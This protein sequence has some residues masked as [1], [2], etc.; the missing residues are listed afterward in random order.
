MKQVLEVLETVSDLQALRAATSQDQLTSTSRDMQGGTIEAMLVTT[1]AMLA[2]LA[3]IQP[4]SRQPTAPSQA[5]AVPAQPAVLPEAQHAA[6]QLNA[7]SLD[8]DC[9][10]SCAQMTCPDSTV[11]ANSSAQPSLVLPTQQQLPQ[12]AGP[13]ADSQSQVRQDLSPAASSRQN[14]SSATQNSSANG[15]GAL[16]LTFQLPP[17]SPVNSSHKHTLPA[18]TAPSTAHTEQANLAVHAANPEL[19]SATAQKDAIDAV[20]CFTEQQTA[21]TPSQ[22]A[23][24]AKH[25]PKQSLYKGYRVDLVALLANLSYRHS[26]AQ[27]KVQQLGCV[28]LLLSQCQVSYLGRKH[29]NIQCYTITNGAHHST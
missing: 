13:K 15:A 29:K 11:E 3:P 10:Q 5:T 8:S 26:A 18:A 19:Q 6:Q 21:D 14:V 1:L 23:E 28:E 25:Y 27:Q 9:Q 22:L 4:L 17:G 16:D 7:V 2:A 12:H 20:Q 24:L